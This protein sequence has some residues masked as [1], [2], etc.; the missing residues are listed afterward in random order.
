MRRHGP[1]P[2]QHTS[3]YVQTADLSRG[4][5]ITTQ[6]SQ[7]FN[8]HRRVLATGVPNAEL[9]A[10]AVAAGVVAAAPK[11]KPEPKTGVF[12]GLS[13]GRC[14]ST[15]AEPDDRDPRCL[16]GC[17]ALVGAA[18]LAGTLTEPAEVPGTNG[19]AVTPAALKVG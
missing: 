13:V 4:Y 6:I 2:E 17:K 16:T 7:T 3:C 5:I 8:P 12:W 19:G 15:V 14:G 18:K 9:T 11:P 1:H 10:A